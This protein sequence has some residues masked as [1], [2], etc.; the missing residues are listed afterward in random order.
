MFTSCRFPFISGSDPGDSSN[1]ETEEN[2]SNDGE[3]N[4]SFFTFYTEPKEYVKESDDNI[5][6]SLRDFFVRWIN[7]EFE[8]DEIDEVIHLD[9]IEYTLDELSDQDFSSIDFSDVDHVTLIGATLLM[10]DTVG[11]EGESVDFSFIKNIKI[12]IKF[13]ESV[14]GS[15]SSSD[16]MSSRYNDS[17]LVLSYDRNYTQLDCD[18]MC[19]NLKVEKKDWREILK[20]HRSFVILVR[21]ELDSIPPA[22]FIYRGKIDVSVGG[23]ELNKP[24]P[25]YSSGGSQNDCNADGAGAQSVSY[26][27]LDIIGHGLGKGG[28][29]WSSQSDPDFQFIDAQNIFTTDSRFNVRVLAYSS[30]GKT[31]DS[32]NKSCVYDALNYSKLKLK[33]GVRTQGSSSYSDTFTFEGVPVD[34]CS[35]VYEYSVP[36]T[37]EPLVLEVLDVEF[38]WT[39]QQ[40]VNAGYDEDDPQL[41]SYCPWWYVSKLDCFEIGIQFSTDYTRD[42]PH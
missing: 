13:N 7:N 25:N 11:E 41:A 21:I 32:Y 15:V 20:K 26:Y 34:G 12:Y 36:Q 5:G 27:N 6:P 28:V 33:I 23:V 1:L 37:S 38:D 24:A 9:P 30:P 16:D 17:L 35:E 10:E 8:T 42:I 14:N 2:A 29:V 18:G 22:N 39:C 31:T 40:Y 4:E 19:L 3:I